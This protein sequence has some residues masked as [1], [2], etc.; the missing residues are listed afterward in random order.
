MTGVSGEKNPVAG[1]VKNEGEEW[2]KIGGPRGSW[3]P[4]SLVRYGIQAEPRLGGG[5][6]DEEVGV[7]ENP[8]ND[9]IL[10]KSKCGSGFWVACFLYSPERNDD[11]PGDSPW[12]SILGASATSR[13]SWDSF[14]LPKFY[15]H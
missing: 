8:D 9:V 2:K 13:W 15:L 11:R 10:E 7:G 14:L 5:Y 6:S 4:F 1:E 3:P 12:F